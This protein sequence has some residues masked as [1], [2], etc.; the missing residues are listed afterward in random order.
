MAEG[1]QERRRRQAGDG[2]GG[3]ETARNLSKRERSVEENRVCVCVLVSAVKLN[4]PLLEKDREGG[5]KRERT[6]NHRKSKISIW[7]P[8]E[9]VQPEPGC[10]IT[11]I[12]LLFLPLLLLFTGPGPGRYALPP[13]VGYV[14]H[15]VTKPSS[16]A[17]SLRSRM[18]SAR[19]SSRDPPVR[20]F[21]DD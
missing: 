4:R 18:S 11:Y 7:N 15:D 19:K 3:E 9:A 5:T 21:W 6:C 8:S 12:S 1:E 17:Y 16:P 13:T 14:N 20:C 10:C 2:R